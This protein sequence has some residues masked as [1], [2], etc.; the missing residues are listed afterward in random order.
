VAFADIEQPYREILGFFEAFRRM[1]FLSDHIFFFQMG[2]MPGKKPETHQVGVELQAQKKKFS[3]PTGFVQGTPETI[4]ARWH[5]I[6]KALPEMSEAELTTLWETSEARRRLVEL[7]LSLQ[8][9]GFFLPM[10][11]S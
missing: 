6:A 5:L 3:V 8:E 1:G 4:Y 9:K 7:V 10:G 2:K 11:M